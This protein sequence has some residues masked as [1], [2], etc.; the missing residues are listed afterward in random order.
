[1][2]NADF[3]AIDSSSSMSERGLIMIEATEEEII[4]NFMK[5]IYG[6][7]VKEYDGQHLFP[8]LCKKVWKQIHFIS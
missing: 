1:M 4:Q 8:A 6:V 5:D 3:K 7:Y 2:E